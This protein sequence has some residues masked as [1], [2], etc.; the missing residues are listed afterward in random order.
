[1]KPGRMAPSCGT[2]DAIPE[3]ATPTRFFDA[4][5]IRPGRSER[6]ITVQPP[7]QTMAS[8]C[9]PALRTPG[10]DVDSAALRPGVAASLAGDADARPDDSSSCHGPNLCPAENDSGPPGMDLDHQGDPGRTDILR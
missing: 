9:R 8:T 6:W 4:H 2:S 7:D 1:M 10:A 5:S 3:P